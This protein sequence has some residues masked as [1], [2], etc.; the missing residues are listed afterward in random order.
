MTSE[1]HSRT[2]DAQIHAYNTLY[3]GLKK[4][5]RDMLKRIFPGYAIKAFKKLHILEETLCLRC[6]KNRSSYS[7]YCPYHKKLV[8]EDPRPMNHTETI[9]RN[10]QMIEWRKINLATLL[11]LEK[12][13][14]EEASDSEDE[15]ETKSS[16]SAEDE[17]D[18]AKPKSRSRHVHTPRRRRARSASPAALPTNKSD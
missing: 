17:P 11:R 13:K 1:A 2:L 4:D 7:T 10:A 3:Y 9:Q 15:Y 12:E 6:T 5:L 14:Y 8:L 16:R 18:A